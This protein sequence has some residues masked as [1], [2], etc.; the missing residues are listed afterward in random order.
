M[1]QAWQ[2]LIVTTINQ[3]LQVTLYA[4]KTEKL[5]FLHFAF[6]KPSVVGIE[7]VGLFHPCYHQITCSQH[8]IYLFCTCN[9]I[10]KNIIKQQ[11]THFTYLHQC[12]EVLIQYIYVVVYKLRC[13]SYWFTLANN[14]SQVNRH[15]AATTRFWF[16]TNFRYNPLDGDK[17]QEV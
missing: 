6:C 13:S 12:Q 14:F 1:F 9:F 10:R 5:N 17:R 7:E 11:P 3:R 4:I 2:T 8:H 16:Q 15:C